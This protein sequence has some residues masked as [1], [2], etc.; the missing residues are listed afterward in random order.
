MDL[1]HYSSYSTLAS[2]SITPTNVPQQRVWLALIACDSLSNNLRATPVPLPSSSPPVRWPLLLPASSKTTIYNQEFHIFRFIW[3][4]SC[5]VMPCAYWTSMGAHYKSATGTTSCPT[6]Y[7][8]RL[9]ID[10]TGSTATQPCVYSGWKN[11]PHSFMAS[12]NVHYAP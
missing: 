4:M 5:R 12:S 2:P 6:T 1:L 11:L 9:P 3:I 10:G 8:Q 7:L